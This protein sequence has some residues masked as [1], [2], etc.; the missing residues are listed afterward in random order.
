LQHRHSVETFRVTV[1]PHPQNRGTALRSDMLRSSRN[2]EVT[3]CTGKPHPITQCKRI[4]RLNTSQIVKEHAT[5]GQYFE[6]RLQDNQ[7]KKN[8]VKLQCP[9]GSQV[10]P[11]KGILFSLPQKLFAQSYVI[12]RSL[13]YALKF[14]LTMDIKTKPVSRFETN[15]RMSAFPH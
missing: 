5:L 12:P 14:S 15:G 3:D 9:R 4:T 10:V 7:D 1:T 2:M 6:T 8:P 11:A 13:S